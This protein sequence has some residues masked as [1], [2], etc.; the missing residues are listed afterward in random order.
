MTQKLRRTLWSGGF[1]TLVCV[2][3]GLG[4]W[5]YLESSRPK[6]L[7]AATEDPPADG[8]RP[9]YSLPEAQREYLW[10]IEHHNNLLGQHRLKPFAKAL[11]ARDEKALLA[12]FA[13]DFEGQVPDQPQE[14]KIQSNA[15]EVIRRAAGDRP[16]RTLDR[17]QFLDELWALRDVFDTPPSAKLAVIVLKPVNRDALDGPWEG[18]I[19]FRIWGVRKG[20]K[21]AEVFAYCNYRVRRPTEE[22]LT[23]GGWLHRMAFTQIQV[24]KAE[25]FLFRD[26]AAERGL[27]PAKLYDNWKT[28]GRQHI[29]TGGVYVFDFNRD[30]ILDVLVSDANGM[31]LYQGLPSGKFKNVTTEMG[32]VP[33][34]PFPPVH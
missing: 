14:T 3:V 23:P 5:W 34:D 16:L 17:R 21:P 29:N 11:C 27:E 25:R 10:D 4:A 18:A 30:G 1:L 32:L 7:R 22:N 24:G 6:G 26:V 28:T 31:F 2:I 15:V 20:G 13:A 19:Q 8:N 9:H 33:G 12:M